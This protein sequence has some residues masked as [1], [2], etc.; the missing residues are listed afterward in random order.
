MAKF[1]RSGWFIV[2]VATGIN[3]I[4]GLLYIWSIIAAYLFSAY[5]W[6]S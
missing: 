2:A 3:L 5:G 1:K 4:G 6:C